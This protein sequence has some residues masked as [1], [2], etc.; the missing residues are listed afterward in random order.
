[1]N[2]TFL[3]LQK[4]SCARAH[5]VETMEIERLYAALS[6]D[7]LCSEYF[8]ATKMRVLLDF[9]KQKDIPSTFFVIPN[10]RSHSLTNELRKSLKEI[11]A[12][13][14]EV[15]LHGYTHT[16]WKGFKG[17]FGY[18][19]PYEFGYLL[20]FPLPKYQKQMELI[21]MGRRYLRE[22]LD[23]Q[24]TG[25]RAPG[26]RH[27]L[28]TLRALA[29]QGFRYDSSKTV[30]KPAYLSRFRFRTRNKPKPAEI[31]G[32]TEIPVVGDYV[33]NLKKVGFVN[34]LRQAL[35]DF[36]WVRAL[37]G[38]FVVNSHIHYLTEAGMSLLNHLVEKI[39]ERTEFLRLRDL[40]F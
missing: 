27:N 21:R 9:L 5:S 38:V 32:L 35:N 14:H 16:L 24:P 15:G 20:S 18:L 39:V 36:E 4:P 23:I 26:Y 2:E 8:S 29:N 40:A 13:G 37:D 33:Y 28:S 31:E 17:E 1:M 6:F 34:T 19:S 22:C 11:V 12:S 10:F 30:F 25:F 3:V 7:D